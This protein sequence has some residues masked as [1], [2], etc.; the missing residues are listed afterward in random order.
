[1]FLTRRKR[2]V[3]IFVT[4]SSAAITTVLVSIALILGTVSLIH[5]GSQA[6][7]IAD[8]NQKSLE[9]EFRELPPLSQ[10]VVIQHGSMHKSDHGI[11]STA[12][13]TGESYESIKFYYHRELTSRGWNLR[14]EG[15]VLYDGTN[16]GGKELVY[17]KNGYAARLQ[18]AGRQ[19][20]E[21]GW[22]FSFGMTWGLADECK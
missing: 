2:S 1:M 3:I 4:A 19:E 5:D 8:K 9:H 17:C 13:K 12:Y 22:T 16:Y 11:V 6:E 15:G 7:A 21:F 18:Y 10:A 14:K 20:T